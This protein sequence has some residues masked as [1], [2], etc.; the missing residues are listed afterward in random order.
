MTRF[1]VDSG[2]VGG[3]LLEE[4]VKRLEENFDNLSRTLPFIKGRLR[5]DRAA[6][7]TSNDVQSPDK[8]YDIVVKND[9]QYILIN[10]SGV[11]QW[12]RITLSSF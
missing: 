3:T 12:R 11:L 2:A 5:I 9:Y 6:P 10:N 1:V 8:I 4:R 7:T